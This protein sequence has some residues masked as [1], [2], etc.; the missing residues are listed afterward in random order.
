MIPNLHNV[1]VKPHVGLNEHLIINNIYY[2]TNMT[3]NHHD[4]LIFQE[5]KKPKGEIK[6]AISL[7]EEQKEAK[8]NIL[9]NVVTVLKGKAGSGKSLLAAQVA[10]DLLFKKDIEKVIITRPT[11]VAGNDIG[12]LPGDINEKLAPFTAPV[13]EN[14]YRLYNKEKIEK[15]V[16]DGQIEILPIAFMRGRNFSNCLVIVDEGQNVTDTQMELILTRICNGSRMIICGDG[17]QI[18]LKDKKLSGFDFVCKHFT[19]VPGFG[20][21][22]L[23]TNHRHEI[24]ENILNVYSKYR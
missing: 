3:S 19:D 1:E 11:V 6:F 7:N 5:K 21:V 14:M 17:D 24:V 10:L 4:D 9:S 18:D 23:K 20:I 15:L 2:K 13:Y 8:R 22:A 12:F 16:T